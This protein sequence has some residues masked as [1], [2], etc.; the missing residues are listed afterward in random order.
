MSAEIL[1]KEFWRSSG[2]NL[3]AG[4]RLC[5]SVDG[6]GSTFEEAFRSEYPGVVRVISP[7]VGSVEDAE[8]I[9]QDAFVKAYSR[10]K[11]IGGY[12][13][14]GAWIRRVAIR[15]AVRFVERRRQ[16]V[17]NS[18]AP[19]D[20]SESVVGAIDLNGALLQLSPKQRACVVLH[21][22]A[23]WPVAEVAAAVGCR[24]ATV[25]VHLHRAR[26]ALA[27]SL[28]PEEEMTDGR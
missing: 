25:R 19:A 10:W 16:S 7:I 26:G 23:D 13:R 9:T 1:A 17:P 8:A 11:R 12:D 22:L 27:A 5:R 6:P 4:L 15:D 24:E 20:S 28:D 2:V 3:S 18:P 21:Y 14:P